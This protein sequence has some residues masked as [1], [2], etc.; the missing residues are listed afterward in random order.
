MDNTENSRALVFTL[1]NVMRDA[2]E[3]KHKIL[4]IQH[5]LRLNRIGCAVTMDADSGKVI[6]Y[7]ER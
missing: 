1:Q 6:I 4:S 5:A 2:G 7:S 3:Q